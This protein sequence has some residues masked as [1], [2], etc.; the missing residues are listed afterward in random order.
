MENHVAEILNEAVLLD[1][2]STKKNKPKN[3]R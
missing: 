3:L 1:E 2:L